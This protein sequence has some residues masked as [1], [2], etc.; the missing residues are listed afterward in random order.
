MA[1]TRKPSTALRSMSE[2]LRREWLIALLGLGV[3]T[4]ACALQSGASSGSASVSPECSACH[5]DEAREVRVSHLHRANEQGCLFCHSPHAAGE[6][7]GPAGSHAGCPDCH[8]SVLAQFAQPFN[9]PLGS[10][11]SCTSCHPPH[12]MARR[13]LREHVRHEACVECHIEKEGPFLFGH[14]GDRAL[15]CLSCHEPHG[16]SNPRLLTHH[17]SRTLCHSC[18]INLEDIHVENPGAVFRDCLLCHTEIHGSN[19]DR[20]FFR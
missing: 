19:W 13:A 16:S 6:G 9:H 18:H 2:R 14:E 15:L 20:T 8:A 12:G 4:T 11:I 5:A 17:D 10:T 3:A 1:A 7:S